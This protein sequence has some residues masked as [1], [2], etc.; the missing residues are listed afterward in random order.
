MK[1]GMQVELSRDLLPPEPGPRIEFWTPKNARVEKAVCLSCKPWGHYVHWIGDHSAPCDLVIGKDSQVVQNCEHCQ[2][3][4]PTR[5]K[6]YLY[7]HR[8]TTNGLSFLCLTPMAG[9]HVME[10]VKKGEDLRGLHLEV[11]RVKGNATGE[12]V[13]R[14][15]QPLSRTDVSTPDLDPGPY[16]DTLFRRRKR[17]K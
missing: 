7:V 6:G 4:R 17:L 3:E 10:W 13:V 8:F 12:L 1:G 15:A 5:Y 16:L 14:L 2:A 11:Y 9:Y